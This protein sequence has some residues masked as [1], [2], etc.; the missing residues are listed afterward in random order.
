[1]NI[2]GNTGNMIGILGKIWN[3]LALAKVCIL[4]SFLVLNHAMLTSVIIL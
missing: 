3:K 2:T 1:M 4:L